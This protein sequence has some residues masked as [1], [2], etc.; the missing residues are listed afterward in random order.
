MTTAQDYLDRIAS[1]ITWSSSCPAGATGWGAAPWGASPWGGGAAAAGQLCLGL[2]I[3]IRE[4]V[5]RMFFSAPVKYTRWYDHGDASRLGCYSVSVVGGTGIDGLAAREV[6]PAAVDLVRD[7]DGRQI[8]LTVDRAFSPYGVLYAVTVTG[9]LSASGLMLGVG[10]NSV[11]FQGLQKGMPSSLVE[12]AVAT[13]DIANPQT[14]GALFDPLPEA[15]KRSDSLLGTYRADG[16]GDL[17]MDVG[18]TSFKKRVFRRLTTKKGRFGHLPDYG[19]TLVNSV[20]M[21]ARPGVTDA[22]AADAEEQIRMEPE[23][24]AVSVR[25]EVTSSGVAFYR[26]AVRMKSGRTMDRA[27]PVAFSPT[28]VGSA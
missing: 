21:L 4:N 22:L 18:L 8:D 6:S 13:G 11:Q 23:T 5:V 25:V 24:E 15:G 12:H 1:G 26:V 27:V 19:V 20:K 9:I 10:A 7:S 17:A 16:T 3:A 14:L 28:E 2:A